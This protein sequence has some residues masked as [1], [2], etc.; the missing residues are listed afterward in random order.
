M[1]DTSDQDN[2]PNAVIIE[3]TAHN[4]RPCRI[5]DNT[6]AVD[7]QQLRALLD[8]LIREKQFGIQGLSSSGGETIT[9]G[10]PRFTHVQLGDALY[11]LLLFPY[12]ARI[13]KY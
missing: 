13:E 2:F 3:A 6:G 4:G 9:I 7:E 5:I 12:E 1:T 11:R 10:G 8:D